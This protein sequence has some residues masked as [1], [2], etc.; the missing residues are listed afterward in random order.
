MQSI[1]RIPKN[2]EIK[3]NLVRN[4]SSQPTSVHSSQ[5]ANREVF[6]ADT[7]SLEKVKAVSSEL[8]KNIIKA[9]QP[10][11]AHCFISYRKQSLDLHCKPDDW[12]LYEM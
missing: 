11:S 6:Q 3:G 9:C 10:I 7:M 8:S 4:G 5:H 1:C 12:F 2:V